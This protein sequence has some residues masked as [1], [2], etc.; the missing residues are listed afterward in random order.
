[1]IRSSLFKKTALLA[2]LASAVV[3]SACTSTI[4]DVKSDG[5]A[6][7]ITFPN[8]KNVIMDNGQGIYPNLES[9]ALIT[10]GMTKDQIQELIGHPHFR[11]GM[12]AVREWDYLF[13]FTT[14]GRGV[15]GVTTCQFKVIYDSD[16]KARSF[17]W[18]AVDAETD[19]CPP[20]IHGIEQFELATDGLFKFDRSSIADMN[21]EGRQNL[22]NIAER[23][24]TLDS[25]DGITVQAHADRLGTAAYNKQLSQRRANSVK[26]YLV[27]QGIPASIINAVGMGDVQPVVQCNDVAKA[28][29]IRCLAPNRRVEVQISGKGTK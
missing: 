12:F 9:L 11:E 6:E 26:N 29:L 20:P 10:D 17:F 19:V 18:K 13:H 14:P 5:T 24:K 4:S 28:E 16:V 2:V 3:L 8:P 22:R 25:V 1:M 15:N 7:N 23:I 27:S 21:P